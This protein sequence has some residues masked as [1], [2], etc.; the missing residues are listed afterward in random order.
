MISALFSGMQ[1]WLLFVILVFGSVILACTSLVCLRQKR[2]KMLV[3][4]HDNEA[5]GFV[6]ATV[7]VVYAVLLAFLVVSVWEAFGAAQHAVADEAAAIVTTARYS[8]SFPEPIRR[9]VHDRLLDYTNLVTTKEWAMMRSPSEENMGSA[10]ARDDIQGI[11]D[12]VQQKMPPNAVSGDALNSINDLSRDRLLR[13]LSSEDVVPDFVWLVL[14]GGA[15]IVIYFSLLLRVE[16]PRLHLV[17]VALLTAS[18]GL[19]IWLMAVINSPFSGELQ[20]ST[21]PLKYAIGVILSLP[22]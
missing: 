8:A 13:L 7:S 17:L 11:W 3:E 18:I 1:V 9:E 6:F 16:N 20:V 15:I 10:R 2:E 4:I 22:R 12:V 21:A 14:L 19:C 5:V